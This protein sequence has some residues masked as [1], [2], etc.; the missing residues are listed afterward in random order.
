[1]TNHWSP[2]RLVDRNSGL[3]SRY[4]IVPVMPTPN[5]RMHLGHIAGP[6]LKSD[7]LAR[8]IRRCGREV[9]LVSGPDAYESHVAQKADELAVDCTAVASEFDAR[10]QDDLAKLGIEFDY[11]LSPLDPLF[12]QRHDDWNRWLAGEIAKSPHAFNRRERILYDPE[13]NRF[14]IG[15]LLKGMC[16]ECGSGAG[17]YFCEECG[18]HFRPERI[19]QEAGRPGAETVAAMIDSRF[20]KAADTRAIYRNA[21]EQGIPADLLN[22]LG[23][24]LETD[25]D[26]RIS[27]PGR[28]GVSIP[29]ME[30]DVNHV[31]FSY[32]GLY[33]FSLACAESHDKAC[34]DSVNSFEEGSGITTVAAFGSDNLIPYL[35]GMEACAQALPGY[36]S[37][38]H[39]LTNHMLRLNGAKFSTSRN[40]VIW[41]GDVVDRTSMSPDVLRLFLARTSP[42]FA[43]SNLDIGEM[44]AFANDQADRLE[45]YVGRGG[46]HRFI[47]AEAPSG[48]CI[49]A[50]EQALVEQ[51]K[52]LHPA[53]VDL[54]K[55]AGTVSD[56]TQI[57]PDPEMDSGGGYWWLKGFALLAYPFMPS[58]GRRLWRSLGHNDEPNP[59]TFMER[60]ATDSV[61]PSVH[62][63]RVSARDVFDTASV[64]E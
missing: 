64:Q 18:T 29:D 51:F 4:L 59:P 34:R 50:L 13:A 6:Y 7:V 40:H 10:I 31:V 15:A 57:C 61:W 39:H 43:A 42:Q 52:T 38:D 41:A 47:P 60:P 28:W 16:P 32:A 33:P 24:Y 49:A 27:N 12:G 21:A 46:G 26:A 53:T 37:F 63:G 30:G 17:S 35:V 5:G 45:A 25:G 55:A 3:S 20:L 48:A 11:W 54:P 8:H 22:V 56:W 23:K 36:R 58:F 1:M 2:Q 19:R 14:Q 44:V 9:S 62:L